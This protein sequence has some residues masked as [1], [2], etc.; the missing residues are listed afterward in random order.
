MENLTELH[1][2]D[3]ANAQEALSGQK[4][5]YNTRHRDVQFVIDDKVLKKKR[6]L[7]LAADWISAELA[8]AYRTP[9]LECRIQ[10]FMNW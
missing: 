10:K 1:D 9:Y 7:S 2:K 4:K 3:S 5:N 6:I 8:S